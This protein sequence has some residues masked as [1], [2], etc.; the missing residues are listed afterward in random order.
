MR[1]HTDT[2]LFDPD[3]N[4]DGRF[5]RR[6]P[7][8]TFLSGPQMGRVILLAKDAFVFGR[9]AD[10]DIMVVDQAI[11]RR[12]GR[13]SYCPAT[14]GYLVTD[15]DSSNGTFVNDRRITEQPLSAGDKIIMGK[16]ILKFSLADAVDVHYM[17]EM[18]KL[19]TVDEL[20]G[21]PSKRR[22]DEELA[23]HVAVAHGSSKPLGMLMMDM[24]GLKRINDTHGHQFGAFSIAET[25]K[26]I[27]GIV[28]GKGLASRYGGDEFMAFLVGTSLNGAVEVAE[29]IRA[30][31]EAH[32][33]CKEG[34]TLDPTIS[35][36]AAALVIGEGADGLLRRA[37]EALYRA[38]QAGRNRVCT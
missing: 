20:T 13:V 36:G 37:D 33:Y 19:I 25:G 15:L 35:I 8:L 23:R 24:D 28:A 34:I 14:D 12:H 3:F 6:Q 30:A 18:E 29:R 4:Q 1:D 10:A 21:L 7:I 38:K 27:G 32:D 11:S 2:E 5:H 16:T 17:G 26:L 9:S 22:F 31:V